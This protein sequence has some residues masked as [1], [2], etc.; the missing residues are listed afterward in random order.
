MNVKELKVCSVEL[1]DN[2]GFIYITEKH[3]DDKNMYETIL[4]ELMTLFV[5][6]GVESKE[7]LLDFALVPNKRSYLNRKAIFDVPHGDAKWSYP[8]PEKIVV[9]PPPEPT[10][11]AA[12]PNLPTLK[13][14]DGDAK[15]THWPPRKP[16]T[17]GVGKP[18]SVRKDE[19][20]MLEKW[21]QP[22]APG[23]DI[24]LTISKVSASDIEIK[25]SDKGDVLV[26]KHII[27]SKPDNVINVDGS[28][29]PS[30]KT[31]VADVVKSGGTKSA[32]S[33]GKTSSKDYRQTANDVVVVDSDVTTESEPGHKDKKL[34]INPADGLKRKREPSGVEHEHDESTANRRQ[35]D[36]SVT[37]K[38]K[39]PFSPSQA[40][41]KPNYDAPVTKNVTTNK[42]DLSVLGHT[43]LDLETEY[44][45]LPYYGNKDLEEGELPSYD[46]NRQVDEDANLITSKLGEEIV[47]RH[48]CNIYKEKIAD[49]TV[50]V[51]WLNS[52][53]ESKSPYD[54]MISF[55]DADKA[56]PIYI[57]VKT[58]VKDE[59][60]EFQIS[61][62]QLKFAF[63]E[64][65]CFH[66]YRVSNIYRMSELKIK[67]LVN[68]S[69]Y[70]DRKAVKL[71]ML[72]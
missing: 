32:T 4:S 58:T 42:V 14:P 72:L 68:L 11:V 67:R 55:S 51:E 39:R 16:G 49:G 54:L 47:F 21:K 19:E 57:E 69:A 40:T 38:T 12:A 44:E 6:K 13:N 27:P 61:S 24:D 23:M 46:S 70:M 34:S 50:K 45:D 35:T 15:V 52:E 29:S 71:F 22:D 66:L 41:E 10:P 48:L 1:S 36:N 8:E 9:A 18:D 62:Q 28:S 5:G 3:V 25:S 60:R 30:K 63:T 43:G 59:R 31:T 53:K 56:L 37:P 65:Q 20:E 64:G 26:T 17:C 33:P 7:I 2:K